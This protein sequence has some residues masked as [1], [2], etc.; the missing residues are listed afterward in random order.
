M[1]KS[2]TL[3]FF[4]PLIHILIAVFLLIA[5]LKAA[6]NVAQTFMVASMSA[7]TNL[8]PQ[9]YDYFLE[10]SIHQQEPDKNKIHCYVDY[11]EHLLEIF[12]SLW[13]AYGMLGYC[14]HY[15][16]DEEK[17]IKYLNFAINHCPEIF[18]NYYNLAAIYIEK[19][20]YDEASALLQKA[21]RI[22]PATSLKRF[23]SSQMIYL[24]LLV[25]D[26][27]KAISYA[28]SHFQEGFQVSGMI[29]DI[30]NHLGNSQK[31]QEAIKQFQPKLYA[32]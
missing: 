19:H 2:K 31:A 29:E 10:L 30:I 8:Q 1:P 23:F 18:W 32:F 6:Q 12:P 17:A 3:N 5:F 27:K 4:Y 14:Y 24:P 13:E 11:Y 9:P 26:E 16:G 15:L 25:P 20:R 7:L 21:R 28:A 22:S